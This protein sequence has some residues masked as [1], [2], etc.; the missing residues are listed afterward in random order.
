MQLIKDKKENY[1]LYKYGNISVYLELVETINTHKVIWHQPLRCHL[2]V[3]HNALGWRKEDKYSL[4]SPQI[5]ALLLKKIGLL[6][7]ISLVDD[8]NVILRP[9]NFRVYG[10]LKIFKTLDIESINRIFDQSFSTLFAEGD[11][12]KSSEI[13]PYLKQLYELIYEQTTKGNTSE[14]N[15]A[16]FLTQ[17]KTASKKRDEQHKERLREQN[18]I[19]RQE[20]KT[21]YKSS[22]NLLAKAVLQPKANFESNDIVNMIGSIVY[23]LILLKRY[24]LQYVDRNLIAKKND[25][26]QYTP[27]EYC[28][29]DKDKAKLCKISIKKL[30]EAY[31]TTSTN[32]AEL[33]DEFRAIL[34]F[35]SAITKELE[36]Q[37]ILW[38][39][40]IETSFIT[41]LD[42]I[43]KFLFYHH[44]AWLSLPTPITPPSNGLPQTQSMNFAHQVFSQGWDWKKYPLW[45]DMELADKLENRA[46]I[47]N[48]G[49]WSGD[50]IEDHYTKQLEKLFIPNNAILKPDILALSHRFHLMRDY[51]SLLSIKQ[52]VSLELLPDVSKWLNKS[53]DKDIFWKPINR[54]PTTVAKLEMKRIYQ[55]ELNYINKINTLQATI[56]ISLKDFTSIYQ[57]INS[58]NDTNL[59]DAGTKYYEFANKRKLGRYITDSSETKD[60]K[61]FI[62]WFGNHQEHI[63]YYIKDV[64]DQIAL[65]VSL[66]NTAVDYKTTAYLIA[67]KVL[68]RLYDR[69]HKDSKS[70][71]KKLLFPAKNRK[72][73]NK[74][75]TEILRD[76][77]F[78]PIV[79]CILYHLPPNNYFYT[80]LKLKLQKYR[81]F[82]TFLYHSESLGI[83]WNL[84]RK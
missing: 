33:G 41:P 45:P 21:R 16:D 4:T 63:D 28:T 77:L 30:L 38:L 27:L 32:H 76:F 10:T 82:V 66:E 5:P 25:N 56:D 55:K 15:T 35:N 64:I 1:I 53:N 61:T 78:Q 18:Q 75:D 59:L 84:L 11:G 23:I 42:I 74:E 24:H 71:L 54:F 68:Y 40:R 7:N 17:I 26:K 44:D 49:D 29:Y 37:I 46:T 73:S 8:N 69:V 3:E 31:I 51:I 22:S 57:S 72:G 43:K 70:N 79:I 13:K 47:Y 34:L 60:I 14:K 52:T 36:Y 65:I 50:L 67:L 20:L 19:K 81:D 48:K 83:E 62:N 6:K 2:L 12:W 9:K 39:A 80:P 58:T